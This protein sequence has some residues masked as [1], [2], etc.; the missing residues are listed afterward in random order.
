[1]R[2]SL[3]EKLREYKQK[4]MIIN[5]FKYGVKYAELDIDKLESN[6]RNAYKQGLSFDKR[7]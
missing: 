6:L 4:N 5:M 7:G 1:M 2:K 3:F